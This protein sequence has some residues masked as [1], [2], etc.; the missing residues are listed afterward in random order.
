M[1]RGVKRGKA[2]SIGVFFLRGYMK[3]DI[4]NQKK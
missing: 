3:V 1:R 2:M 4:A